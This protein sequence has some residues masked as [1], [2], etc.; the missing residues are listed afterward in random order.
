MSIGRLRFLAAQGGGAP[1]GNDP[2]AQAYIDALGVAGYTVSGAE[3]TAINNHF[4]DLK[5]TG[6]NNSTYD[7]WTSIVRLLPFIG[8][9]ASQQAIKAESPVNSITFAGGVTHNST[10]VEG[11]GTNG[12]YV[13]FSPSEL[14]DEN[15]WSA[16]VYKRKDIAEDKWDFAAFNNSAGK[17]T[18]MRSRTATFN[19]MQASAG[20]ASVSLQ[21]PGGSI[22]NGA[23]FVGITKYQSLGFDAYVRGA[24]YQRAVDNYVSPGIDVYGLAQNRSAFTPNEYSANEHAYAL[25]TSGV[26]TTTEEAALRACVE[27]FMNALNRNVP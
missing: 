17:A 2:D 7:W 9:T 13:F 26:S 18:Q 21:S 1:P 24:A 20:S 23:G 14:S 22:T 19:N 25:V 27:S 15:D 6:P 12:Y 11:N 5:G 10:G 16:W 8:T 3:E 4:L